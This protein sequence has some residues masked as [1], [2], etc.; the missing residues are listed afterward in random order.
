MDY[1]PCFRV[2]SQKYPKN[3]DRVYGLIWKMC[4]DGTSSCTIPIKTMMLELN[5]TMPT[6]IKLLNFLKDNNFIE[7]VPENRKYISH[8][9]KIVPETLEEINSMWERGELNGR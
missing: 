8:T 6:V 9:Y 5:L 3:V 7:I 1:F 2:L 4:K